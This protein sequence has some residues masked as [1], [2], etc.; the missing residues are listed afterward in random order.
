MGTSSYILTGST[1]SMDISFGS[2]CHGAGRVKARSECDI[3]KED[4]ITDLESKGIS[5][6][7]PKGA[8]ISDEAPY[9]YKDVDLV[10][11][12]CE[13]NDLSRKAAKLIPIGVIKG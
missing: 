6:S 3:P 12:I 7:F 11:D 13:K 5:H 1:G 8:K 10:V 9:A 4:V 2:T